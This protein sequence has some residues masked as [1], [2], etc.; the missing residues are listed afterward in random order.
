VAM[1]LVIDRSGSMEMA[2]G[3][4]SGVAKIELAKEAASRAVAQLSERDY[5]GVITFDSAAS[6]VVELQPLGD[7]ALFKSRIGGVTA[8]GGTDIYA[9]LS[10]AVD[11]LVKSKA[12]SKHIVLL[13]DGVSAPGDYEGL[14]AKMSENAITLS[15]V[16]VGADADTA[17]M[18]WLA[19]QGKG[20]YYYTEDGNALP[21]IF[22][23][24]S[25]IAARSYLIEHEFTPERAFPSPILDALGGLPALLGYVGTSPR[26]GGQ[27]V[28][29]SDAGDPVLA[30]WQYGLGR[31][32]A[33]TSDATGRWGK[34]WVGWSDFARFWQ[35]AARWSTS[36]EAGGALQARVALE[37]G[38]AHVSVDASAPD[39]S[40][41]NDLDA[42]ATIVDPAGLT[43]T[44]QLRQTAAGR[45]EG[46]FPAPEEGAYLLQARAASDGGPTL[47]TTTG[48]VV[49]YS[50]EYRPTADGGALLARLAALTGG[51]VISLEDLRA[52]FAPGPRPVR[53]TTELWPL[54][55]LLA[56]LL[57]PLDVGLRRVAVTRRD[58]ARAWSEAR[59]RVGLG[60]RPQP[61]GVPATAAQMQSLF[62]AKERV[63]E[64][65]RAS[66]PSRRAPAAPVIPEPPTLGVPGLQAQE[67]QSITGEGEESPRP[68]TAPLPP[69]AP[70][71]SEETD[72]TLAARL[73]RARERR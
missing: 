21:E 54:L 30:Q 29:V 73:R 47:S 70:Q 25:H 3:G 20:R 60:P 55:L 53:N 64:R 19:A 51:G 17:L 23:H 46:D 35:Q 9:G 6:W 12:K 65:S 66:S 31:V 69:A 5:A 33:W 26:P 32:V 34:Q 7:P 57:F 39:G 42:G 38:T 28:L 1:V 4:S 14:I 59:R 40:F 48:L 2:H 45:Y 8:G 41:L 22:A 37:A 43:T 44:V 27:I 68:T 56:I 11:A 67:L 18:Q 15:G 61:A 62:S 13:T 72:E 36:A 63:R 71:R 10:P 49:P 52:P 58:L 24:E 50:P 16:A